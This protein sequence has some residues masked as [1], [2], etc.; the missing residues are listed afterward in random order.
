MEPDANGQLKG[1][2]PADYYKDQAA[3]MPDG[4]VNPDPNARNTHYNQEFNDRNQR[5]NMDSAL[6][7]GWRYTHDGLPNQLADGLRGFALNDYTATATAMKPYGSVERYAVTI[8][9][10]SD[11]STVTVILPKQDWQNVLGIQ[12]SK[13]ALANQ[14]KADIAASSE[15]SLPRTATPLV[16]PLVFHPPSRIGG[17]AP[18]YPISQRSKCNGARR[19]DRRPASWDLRGPI[20]DLRLTQ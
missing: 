11:K 16:S 9:R 20:A 18:A 15:Q 5:M 6:V 1:K 3:T 8:T 10:P 13:A 7:N 14:N 19:T 2:Q 12:Q 4:S 17:R